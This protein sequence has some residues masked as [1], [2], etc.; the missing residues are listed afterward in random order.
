[1]NF[2]VFGLRVLDLLLKDK[3]DFRYLPVGETNEEF[4]LEIN[5]HV[6]LITSQIG[7]S[8]QSLREIKEETNNDQELEELFTVILSGR[9]DKFKIAKDIIRTYYKSKSEH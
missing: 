5:A 3:Y 8:S 2:L 4:E 6:N 7:V 9:S 1:M